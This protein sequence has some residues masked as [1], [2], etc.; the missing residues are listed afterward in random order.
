[1]K[2]KLSIFI[3]VSLTLVIMGLLSFFGFVIYP[4]IQR[5]EPSRQISLRDGTD[6]KACQVEV[7]DKELQRQITKYRY[8]ISKDNTCPEYPQKMYISKSEYINELQNNK[9][10]GI[11]DD[12]YTYPD[13]IKPDIKQTNQSSSN[14]SK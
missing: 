4:D 12:N 7:V 10:W 14:S 13:L 1:M 5:N 3:I 11:F 2:P 9:G 6:W 8:V